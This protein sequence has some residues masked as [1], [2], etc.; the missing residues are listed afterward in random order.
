[1]QKHLKDRALVLHSIRWKESSKILT[2]YL[3]GRGILK[4]I[5]RSVYR[6]NNPLSGRLEALNLLE[7]IIVQK[8]SRS[9]QILQEAELLNA[10]SRMRQD[11]ARLP[12][13]L[14]VLEVIEQTI[15]EQHSDEIF[16][17]F[18]LHILESIET[19]RLP[20]ILFI[21]YLL[22]LSSFLG[23]RPAFQ[24]CQSCGKE[25]FKETVYFSV[26][27]GTIFCPECSGDHSY[28]SP[29]REDQFYFL[30]KLQ[31]YPH[32]KIDT[33]PIP[34]PPQTNFI[35]LLARYLGFHLERPLHLNALS[36]L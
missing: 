2:L 30:R 26:E 5:A 14:A 20:E 27:K 9:L 33:F 4:V 10:F 15:G 19:A 28:L 34:L 22:K 35:Q 23:F 7:V 8:P 18:T 6:P 31:T 21:Y 32:K 12:Y 36:L 3:R 1:M 17:D 25:N 24:V 16:F 29:L 11:M 13:A